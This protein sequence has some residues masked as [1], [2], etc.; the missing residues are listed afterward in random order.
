MYP[1]EFFLLLRFLKLAHHLGGADEGE[2]SSGDKLLMEWGND[3][4]FLG[5]HPLY[6]LVITNSHVLTDKAELFEYVLCFPSN[7]YI[8]YLFVTFWLEFATNKL[9]LLNR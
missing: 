3:R 4:L 9:C 5:H 7:E 1:Y 8:P 2:M 6:T